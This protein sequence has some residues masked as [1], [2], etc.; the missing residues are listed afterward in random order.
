MAVAVWR[1]KDEGDLVRALVVG[2]FAPILL[3]SL[4][5]L[6]PVLRGGGHA[7]LTAG[8]ATTRSWIGL[9]AGNLAAVAALLDR[10][11]LLY[12]AILVWLVDSLARGALLQFRLD[13]R[14]SS[15]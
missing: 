10:R 6:V 11:R 7:R 14:S 3:A 8:F 5:Y 1:G 9:A 12:A 4:A 13:K 15:D 2:G